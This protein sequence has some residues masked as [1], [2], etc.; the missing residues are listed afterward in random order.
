[1][2]T[3]TVEPDYPSPIPRTTQEKLKKNSLCCYH[4]KALLS[5]TRKQKL[6]AD[7]C[8]WCKG[9][10]CRGL[11]Q[12]LSDSLPDWTPSRCPGRAWLL[13]RLC[14][15]FGKN[16]FLSL[17]L[18]PLSLSC[19]G[20]LC[21]LPPA[22]EISEVAGSQLHLSKLDWVLVALPMEPVNTLQKK[23]EPSGLVSSWKPVCGSSPFSYPNKKAFVSIY[24]YLA[25]HRQLPL[26]SVFWSVLWKLS[27]G[28]AGS[29]PTP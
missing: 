21:S 13:D 15:C 22:F 5:Q 11:C 6:V 24:N 29:K 25:F 19:S 17:G 20:S 2:T 7:C 10:N 12:G 14:W 9:S 1:M 18:I 27:K 8:L 26:D 23:S 3:S 16:S 4:W 28:Q